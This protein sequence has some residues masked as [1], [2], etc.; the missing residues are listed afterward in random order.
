MKSGSR[1]AGARAGEAWP[2]RPGRAEPAGSSGRRSQYTAAERSRLLSEWKA[3]GLTAEAFAVQQGMRSSSVLY[4]W[5][6][7]AK[8]G[9][10]LSE[11]RG[12]ARNPR[13]KTRRPYGAAE[14]VAAVTAYRSSGLTQRAFA[15]VWG[16][17]LKSLSSWLG[18]VSRQGEAGLAGRKPGRPRGSGNRRKLPAAA[19]AQVVDAAQ[20]HPTFGLKKV[21]Q[22]VLR[23]CGV[24]VSP[25]TVKR[26]LSRAGV[27]RRVQPKPKTRRGPPAVRF[28][29]RARPNQL[30]QSDITSLWLGRARRHLYLTVFL[31][32]HSRYVV[33]W[34]LEAH[35]KSSLVVE[36]LKAALVAWGKPEEVLTDQ[37]PQYFSWRG[38][39]E[40]QRLLKREGIAHVV[41]RS[42]HPETLGKTERLWATIKQELWDRI[43]PRD[44][45]EAQARLGHFI[46]HYNH[47]RPHQGLA[48]AVPADRYFGLESEVRAAIQ[49]RLASNELLLALEQ[50]PRKPVYLLGQIDGQA[51][52]L[53]GER[54]RLVISTPQGGRQEMDMEDLG[55]L[56]E[57][58]TQQSEEVSD[59]EGGEG[60][61][62]GTEAA[63]EVHREA[64]RCEAVGVPGLAGA[65]TVGGG[66]Q[67]AEGAGTPDMHGDSG[68]VA[69]A[70]ELRGGG[71][72]AGCE[73]GACVAIES[74]GPVGDAGGAA[75]AT[76]LAREDRDDGDGGRAR[77]AVTSAPGEPGAGGEAG[78]GGGADHAAAE[79][80]LERATE[81]GAG[82]DG[83]GREAERGEKA[84]GSAE[85][86]GSP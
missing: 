30:W 39:S 45:A 7:A 68:A 23:F 79:S 49:A 50:S 84:G 86:C 32:D 8:Q 51:V 17:S 25:A 43:E 14:R 69:G 78:S 31:D 82:G 63:D 15:Q 13:G 57:G 52:S 46:S 77:G 81:S 27:A 73:P 42:H 59:G 36:C 26:T 65:G 1:S 41:S 44:L 11:S 18:R 24:K 54:G 60:G 80:A 67:R 4:S 16:V 37:G 12:G 76:T 10:P 33:G 35:H 83:T 3:S 9:R 74:V 56:I 29:E 22:Y 85:S 53:H 66:E 5:Q 20:A 62:D 28:F 47:G 2:P 21:S 72:G 75:Q 71:G 70:Q 38:K 55:G 61:R 34:K 6:H 19:A 58:R 40:L 64:D 48:G